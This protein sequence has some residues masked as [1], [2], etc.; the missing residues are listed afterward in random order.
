MAF[1]EGSN[2]GACVFA[3][4]AVMTARSTR[5]GRRQSRLIRGNKDGFEV[6]TVNHARGG[7][8]KQVMSPEEKR[9]AK[10]AGAADARAGRTCFSHEY[11]GDGSLR[12]RLLNLPGVAAVSQTRHQRSARRH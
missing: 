6:C 5:D 12:A 4:T 10:A 1:P 2:R 9:R 7:D 3:Q 8:H 11:V